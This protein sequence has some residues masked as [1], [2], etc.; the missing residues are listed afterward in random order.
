MYEIG[1]LVFSGYFHNGWP[2]NGNDLGWIQTSDLEVSGPEA[3][4]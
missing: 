3:H 1:K 2:L 4:Y